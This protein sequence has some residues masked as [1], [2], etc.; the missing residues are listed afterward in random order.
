MSL[1][2]PLKLITNQILERQ[3]THRSHT[4]RK[5]RNRRLNF[6]KILL[7]LYKVTMEFQMWLAYLLKSKKLLQTTVAARDQY[8][9]LLPP[10]SLSFTSF[11]VSWSIFRYINTHPITYKLY[12]SFNYRTHKPL[13][14]FYF[15]IPSFLAEN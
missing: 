8:I 12:N 5:K 3:L 13:S 10:A 14:D 1:S 7:H 4:K 2:H 9:L 15:C 6:F 11:P